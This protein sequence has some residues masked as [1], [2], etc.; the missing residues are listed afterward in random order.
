M[1]F[2]LC[3]FSRFAVADWRLWFLALMTATQVKSGYEPYFHP[4]F[5]TVPLGCDVINV[6]SGWRRKVEH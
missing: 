3:D 2:D 6:R 4:R 1:N 5:A